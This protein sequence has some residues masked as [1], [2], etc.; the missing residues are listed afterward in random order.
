MRYLWELYPAYCNDFAKHSITRAAMAPFANYLRT[1]DFSTAARVDHFL[2]NSRNVRRRIW[3]AYRRKAQVVHPPVETEAF[4]HEPP[5]GYFLVVSEMVAYKRLDYAIRAFTRSGR[6][7]KVVGDGPEY[8]TLRKLAASNIEFCGRVS[9]AELHDLYARSMALIMP[10]EEDFGMT[11]V[12]SLASGK[13][14]VAFGRGGSVE[15]VGE[16]CGVLYGDPSEAGLDMAV[17]VFERKAASFDPV[18]LRVRAQAFSGPVFDR[19]FRAALSR[20]LRRNRDWETDL[21]LAQREEQSESVG[22][23]NG[24]ARPSESARVKFDSNAEV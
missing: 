13:P 10:G 22:A 18:N 11:M 15:I 5:E 4:Y 16:R 3:K 7:L 12:E 6:R 20:T 17:N 9:D 24:D 1:W 19:D 21:L 8:R 2:A 14:V 23:C